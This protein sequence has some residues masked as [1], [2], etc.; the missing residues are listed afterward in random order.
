MQLTK[1]N[2]RIIVGAVL[3]TLLIVVLIQNSHSVTLTFI[4]ARFNVPL[5]VLVLISAAIGVGI[6]WLLKSKR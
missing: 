4:A 3:V 6:G 2:V 1:K 5:F